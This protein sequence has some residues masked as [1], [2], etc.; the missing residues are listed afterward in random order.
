M[1]KTLANRIIAVHKENNEI[2]KLMVLPSC[3]N[4]LVTYYSHYHTPRFSVF[5]I[6]NADNDVCFSLID[7]KLQV[8]SDSFTGDVSSVK[9][10]LEKLLG[11]K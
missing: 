6:G 5:T 2:Y 3:P 1:K 9:Y 4:F 11:L 10:Q 7:N 8:V